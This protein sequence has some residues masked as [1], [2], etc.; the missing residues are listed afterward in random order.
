MLGKQKLYS[1]YDKQLKMREEHH[2]SV[3]ERIEERRKNASVLKKSHND[4][5]SLLNQLR[6]K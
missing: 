1:K 3:V 5:I 6:N 4:K 2:N